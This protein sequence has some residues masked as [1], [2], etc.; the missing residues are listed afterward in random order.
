VSGGTRPTVLALSGLLCDDTV[1]RAQADA[2]DDLAE[3]ILVDFPDLD[4][5]T[6]MAHHALGLVE[7]RFHLWGHSMGARVAFEVWRTASD[8]VCSLVLFDTASHGVRAAEVPGRRRLLDVAATEGMGRLADEWLPQMVAPEHRS[9]ERLMAQLRAMVLRASPEQHARQIHALLTRPDATP[10]LSTIDVPTLVAVGRHDG[11]SPLAQH[12]KIVE[13]IDGARLEIIEAA[14]HMST[15]EQ[16]DAV[17]AL[18]REWMI[19][20]EPAR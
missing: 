3:F 2:L 15:I 19:G 4:D 10:L 18:L 13:G 12:V 14:G 7:G 5:F 16:P 9:D 17:T 1:W 11:W 20:L 6:D 8:R